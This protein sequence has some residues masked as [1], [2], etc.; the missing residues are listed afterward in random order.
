MLQVMDWKT[1]QKN[2]AW[3]DWAKSEFE[4]THPDVTVEYLIVPFGE[5]RDKLVVNVAG[6]INPDVANMS[7]IWG[8]DLYDQGVLTNLTPMLD[9]DAAEIR[10]DD[11]VPVAHPNVTKG[12]DVFGIPD[13]LGVG[14]LFF[15]ID[16]FQEAGLDT[17]GSDISSWDDFLQAM[18]KLVKVDASGKVARQGYVSGNNIQA[19]TAWLDANGGSFYNEPLTRSN[20]DTLNTQQT[21]EFYADV[22][23]RG[24]IGGNPSQNFTNGGAAVGHGGT[25]TPLTISQQNPTLNYGVMAYPTGPLGSHEGAIVWSNMIAI[26]QASKHKDLAWEWVKFYTSLSAARHRF[27]ITGSPNSSRLDFFN[28]PDWQ[29]VEQTTQW[30][31]GLVHALLTG[32]GVFPF[33]KY[34]KIMSSI[35]QPILDKAIRGEM[36][37]KSAAS[38][39]DRILNELLAE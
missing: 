10:L 2:T 39:S 29:E 31:K 1:G 37:S 33:F 3:F 15:N 11:Y 26:P 19:F 4:R 9:R 24:F 32:K 16:Y 13:D 5:Y 38:E 6:G 18:Q 17:S 23:T 30:G 7:V 14:A 36:G 22:N 12:G 20:L 21:I 25:Y 27:G 34:T 28:S 8:R 35:W